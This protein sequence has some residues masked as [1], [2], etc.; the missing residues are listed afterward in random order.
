MQYGVDYPGV[1]QDRAEVR[2]SAA[3]A[4]GPL[5]VRMRNLCFG[6]DP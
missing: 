2:A 6:F 1:D 5:E 4:K 3:G